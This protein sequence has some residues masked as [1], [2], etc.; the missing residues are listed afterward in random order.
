MEMVFCR[1]CGKEV[2]ETAQ[3]CPHCGAPQQVQPNSNSSRNTGVLIVVACGWTL[4][5]W[6]LI[7]FIGGMIVGIMNPENAEA[8]GGEFGAAAGIPILLVSAVIS[9]LL[10]KIGKL[11]GTKKN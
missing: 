3:N 10:T 9:G 2:H 1:G 7:I 8:A 6:F 5:I 4:I 11:P